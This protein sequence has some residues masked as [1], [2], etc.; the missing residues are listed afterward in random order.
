MQKVQVCALLLC[1][2]Y[3]CVCTLEGCRRDIRVLRMVAMTGCSCEE[4]AG[5]IRMASV[6]LQFGYTEKAWAV[7][8][9]RQSTPSKREAVLA[10][11]RS[12]GATS[13]KKVDLWSV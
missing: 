1:V 9:S 12:F 8:A 10:T 2:S 5:S 7:P 13:C 4:E 3:I 11:T 6:S